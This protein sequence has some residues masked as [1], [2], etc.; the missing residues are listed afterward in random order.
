MTTGKELDWLYDTVDEAFWRDDFVKLDVIL[1]MLSMSA[2]SDCDFCLGV[3]TA[4]LP[5]KNRLKNRKAFFDMCVERFGD[6]NEPELFK[7]L[8]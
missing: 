3:L 4:T 5:G 8:E 7:G 2:P 1:R 6:A